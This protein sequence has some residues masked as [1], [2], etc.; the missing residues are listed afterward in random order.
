RKPVAEKASREP[1]AQVAALMQKAACVSCP[2]A[3][4]AKPRDPSHPKIGGQHNDYL[5]VA[6]KAYKQ[7]D[8][9]NV[10]RN[11]G[12]MGAIAKQFS[13][14]ELKALSNYVTSLA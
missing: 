14:A 7:A 4:L 5:F 6:L 13:N 2:G 1:D 9:P 3:K 12:V 10:G 11:N 8:N